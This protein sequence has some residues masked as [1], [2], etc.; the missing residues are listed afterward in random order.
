MCSLF[1]P[2][3]QTL[4]APWT[5]MSEA[6]LNSY[7]RTLDYGF[8]PE[9]FD[10]NMRVITSSA[11]GAITYDN[12]ADCAAYMRYL[13]VDDSSSGETVDYSQIESAMKILG[14]FEGKYTCSGICSTPLFYYT[15]D[16]DLGRPSQICLTHL[17]DE[18]G[19]NILYM[20]V[21]AVVA[22]VAMFWSWIVQYL[23]W[24]PYKQPEY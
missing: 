13:A 22:G 7:K 21:T 20:G 18:I 24:A 1:C 17:K 2:C 14:Y 23:L 15:L 16:L 11:Q 4:A 8:T 3:D 19:E 9:D 10:G 6:A 12:F 5:S